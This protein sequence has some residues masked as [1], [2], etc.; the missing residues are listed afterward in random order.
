MAFLQVIRDFLVPVARREISVSAPA[1]PT[2]YRLD[3]L[4][5]KHLDEVL[6]LNLRCFANG[7]NYTKHTFSYLLSQP[8]AL[9]FQAVTAEGKMAAFVCVLVAD[10]GTA[11]VTTIGVAP[12]HRRRGLG[13]R[14][15]T[16]LESELI[17]HGV[18][19]VV[20]EVRVSNIN[21]QR[22][23]KACDFIVVQRISGYY[24]DGEDA[25]L[26]IKALTT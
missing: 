21:A 18:G 5:E 24:T 4:Q 10:D 12:E 15:L 16:H 11:H 19:S 17:Q 7:E 13:E 20:L 14:L 22:L 6:R 8:K 2:E 26:M 9:C 1:A 3:R 23:Y 25:F